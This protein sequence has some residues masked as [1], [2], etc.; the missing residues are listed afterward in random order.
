ML[1]P[2]ALSRSL[3]SLALILFS[4]PWADPPLTKNT[5]LSNDFMLH[6]SPL[7]LCVDV[8][9]CTSVCQSRWLAEI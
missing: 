2:L 8:S 3:T 1:V 6:V 5:Y 7:L 9:V 4:S